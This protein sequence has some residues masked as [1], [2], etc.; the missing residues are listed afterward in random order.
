MSVGDGDGHAK[1]RPTDP[2]SAIR[3][4]I[5]DDDAG[6][7]EFLRQAVTQIITIAGVETAPSGQDALDR[8]THTDY[9]VIL[10]DIEMPAMTGIELARNVLNRQVSPTVVLMTENP[11]WLSFAVNSGAFSCVP[12]PIQVELLDGVLRRAVDFNSLHRRVERLRQVLT[13]QTR[14]TDEYAQEVQVRTL[15]IEKR[16]QE[17]RKTELEDMMNLWKRPAASGRTA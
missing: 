16:L 6:S 4:L 9:H 15:G 10:S 11:A 8:A 1:A 2:V 5:V 12:K 7:L 13:M 17:M 3:I 14:R